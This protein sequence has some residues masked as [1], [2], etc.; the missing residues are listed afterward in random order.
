[1]LERGSGEPLICLDGGGELAELSRLGDEVFVRE[2]T[3]RKL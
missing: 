3:I 1:M 2:K